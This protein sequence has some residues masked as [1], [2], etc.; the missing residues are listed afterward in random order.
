MIFFRHRNGFRSCRTLVY[1]GGTM[2]SFFP[3]RGFGLLGCLLVFLFL[4]RAAGA[5]NGPSAAVGLKCEYLTDPLGLDVRAPR[6]FWTLVHASR[7]QSQR[8]FQILVST[9]PG[10]ARGDMW[11]SGKVSSPETTHV[12]YRGKPLASDASYFWKVRWWDKDGTASPWSD[13]ARFDTGLF[14]ADEWKGRW[15]GGANQ[16]RQE[17]AVDG[18][19]LRA[20]AYVCGLGYHELR[21]NGRKVGANVLDP[22]WTTYDKR[23][24]YVTYDLAPYLK[25]GPNAVG[26]MLGDGWF[27]RKAL[28][29][30]I[31]LVM[32]GGKK[33]VI[34]TDASWR[35]K[36]GP[37]TSDSIY[38]GET[39]DARLETPGWDAP[40][41]KEAGWKA[42][43]VVDGP[44]GVLSAQLMPPIRVTDTLVPLHMT[45]PAPG[46]YVFDMGQNA[47]GWARLR[48]SGPAGTAVRMRFAEL[49]YPNGMI[50]QENLRSA[51]AEDT[52]ILK[53]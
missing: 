48:V 12:V 9:L 37:V 4:A 51:R 7:G 17:F 40:G 16:L 52:Y 35:V 13:V 42:A 19:V 49:L 29:A 47:S 28:L 6:L 44:K 33:A 10:C 20:R 36:D 22:A 25:A 5:Q 50:N 18:E 3:V 2:A 21:V 34:A 53:G 1:R 27:K 11:D 41:F 31:H 26:V 23:A 46:V 8:A 30:Q 15:I 39:Y 32:A 24:L 45:H 14:E 38:N 43:R